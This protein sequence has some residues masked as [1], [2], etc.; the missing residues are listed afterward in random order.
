VLIQSKEVSMPQTQGP[1][2]SRDE[3][4]PTGQLT[5]IALRGAGQVYDLQMRAARMMF[6]T[7]ARAAA[8]FGW[9][10][11]SGLFENANE[12]M[13]LLF[14]EAAEQAA[15]NAQ[16]ANEAAAELQREVSRLID[17]QTA[18]VAENWRGGLEELGA[19]A[20]Q[21]LTELRETTRRTVEEA[22]QATRAAGAAARE[23]LREGGEAVRETVREGSK[24]SRQAV[25]ES[26][27]M[28]RQAGDAARQGAREAGEAARQVAS[29]AGEAA[30]QGAVAGQPGQPGRKAA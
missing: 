19:Q 14:G 18:V 8:A 15:S 4:R 2:G 30:R 9:P 28:A 17:S 25:R 23:L 13:R 1:E 7:Q 24:A 21:G 22:E 5:N 6:R 26:G 12:R 11:L 16:R 3:N 10:D 29:E 27:E 20:E